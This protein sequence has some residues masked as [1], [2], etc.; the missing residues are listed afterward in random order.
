LEVCDLFGFHFD[1]ENVEIISLRMDSD[2]RHQAHGY[3]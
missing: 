1:D 2:R 3:C